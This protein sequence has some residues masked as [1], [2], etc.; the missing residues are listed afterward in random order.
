MAGH[1]LSRSGAVVHNELGSHA[2]PCRHTVVGNATNEEL[3]RS[4]GA[5]HIVQ[6]PVSSQSDRSSQVP[7][8]A[9]QER[10]LRSAALKIAQWRQYCLQSNETLVPVTSLGVK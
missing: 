9:G 10:K 8:G 3:E 7:G 6:V 2:A 5:F 1:F 4:T